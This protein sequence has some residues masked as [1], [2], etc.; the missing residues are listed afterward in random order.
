MHFV[1]AIPGVGALPELWTFECKAC[2]VVM[3][4]SKAEVLKAKP[5][6]AEPPTRVLAANR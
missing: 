5:A 4:E 2:A 6:K 3:T 1:R